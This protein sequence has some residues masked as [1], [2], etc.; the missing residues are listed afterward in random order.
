M[1]DLNKHVIPLVVNKWY[2]LGLELLEP[3]HE[4]K[5]EVIQRNHETD[6]EKSCRK[7]FSEWLQTQ[8]DSASWDKLIRVVKSIKLNNAASHIEK[9]LNF[10][11]ISLAS[12]NLKITK[13]LVKSPV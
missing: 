3:E 7:M 6:V 10:F 11:N 12:S 4:R 9:L 1:K 5:L 13:C 8:P 2:N